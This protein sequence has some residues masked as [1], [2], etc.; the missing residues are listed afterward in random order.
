[1]ASKYFLE[2]T[3][4]FSLMPVLSRYDANNDAMMGPGLG[5]Y[6]PTSSDSDSSQ[7][8]SKPYRLCTCE[9]EV[10]A[11]TVHSYLL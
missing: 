5:R 9:T 7:L 11:A 3:W 8:G 2:H 4:T 6:D 10:S 1:M